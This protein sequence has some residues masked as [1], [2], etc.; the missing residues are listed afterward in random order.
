MAPNDNAHREQGDDAEEQAPQDS[1]LPLGE[2]LTDAT[3]VGDMLVER[4]I[5]GDVTS[6]GHNSVHRGIFDEAPSVSSVKVDNADLRHLFYNINHLITD[7]RHTQKEI[8]ALKADT[9]NMLA[10]FDVE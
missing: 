5:S 1:E 2:M 10:E 6:I 3:S 7:M 4:D 8:D 9:R